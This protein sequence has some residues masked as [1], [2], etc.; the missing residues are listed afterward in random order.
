MDGPFCRHLLY[1]DIIEM[2]GGKE[3]YYTPRERKQIILNQAD[4]NFQAYEDSVELTKSLELIDEHA[5]LAENILGKQTEMH[6]N[7]LE[8]ADLIEKIEVPV[9]LLSDLNALSLKFNKQHSE[10]LEL[11]REY[12][13]KTN[14][15]ASRSRAGGS[16][17][18]RKT[19]RRR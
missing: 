10:L 3:T 2:K 4:K 12:K 13:K 19:R 9:N 15:S 8:A 11:I 16:C 14:H 18:K 7:I 17:K 5:E 1:R 6:K